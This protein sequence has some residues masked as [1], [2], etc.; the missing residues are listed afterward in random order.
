MNEIKMVAIDLDDTLLRDDI[1][2]SDHT[3]HTIGLARK[4]DVTVVIAT[5]R[6]FST[7]QPYGK[8]LKLGDIPMMLYSGA[9]I[10]TVDTGTILYHC[11]IDLQDANTLLMLAKEKQ[12]FLQTYIDDVVRVPYYN[13]YIENYENITGT[14]ALIAGERFYHPEGRPSKMLVHGTMHELDQIKKEIELTMPGVFKLMRSKETM[15]EIVHEGISKGT[16]L[17]Q[18]CS[19]FHI[20]PENV[21][22]I[23]NSQNDIAMME[24]AGFSVAVANAENE[25]RQAAD[26][27]TTSNN[28]DGVAA[29]I[30]KFIL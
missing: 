11:P 8:Q 27:V 28:D 12:W 15:L 29:A 14:K 16:G 18:L 19:I 13:H 3:V 25:I 5:G 22:A 30:E 24:T 2:V 21:M 26:F 17:R 23:G 1:T 4:K 10:Q 7:A 9:L 6:M 20:Q